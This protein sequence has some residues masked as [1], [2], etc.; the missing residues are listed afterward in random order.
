LEEEDNVI[1]I[2]FAAVDG[3]Q[4]ENKERSKIRFD[5]KR[6]Y[7]KIDDDESGRLE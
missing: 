5:K 1:M 4:Q 6:R 7:G 3:R 2:V